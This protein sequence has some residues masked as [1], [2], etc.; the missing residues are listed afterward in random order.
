M[1]AMMAFFAVSAFAVTDKPSPVPAPEMKAKKATAASDTSLSGKIVETMNSGGYTYVQLENKGKK[2]WV[3][4]PEMQVSVGQQISLQPG[5]EMVNFTSKSLGK[6]FD[7]II[8]SGG[9]VSGVPSAGTEKAAKKTASPATD[10]KVEKAA[11]SNAYTIGD[12]YKKRTALHNKTAVVKGKVVK[13]SA[14]IMGTNFIH[15]QDG[16]GDPK[17]GTSDLVATSDDLPSTGDVIT[18]KGTVFKD[19]DF[20]AGYKYDVILEKASIQR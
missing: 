4:I 5:M 8:F 1:T 20:G 10:I 15:L 13:V 2:T 16:T 18:I 17:Q 19:K 14:G 9:P 12:I 7:S 6:T 11:G 3:A